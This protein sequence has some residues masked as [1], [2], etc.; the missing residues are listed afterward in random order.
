MKGSPSL[1]SDARGICGMKAFK[2]LLEDKSC[3]AAGSNREAAISSRAVFRLV[4]LFPSPFMA[5]GCVPL[6]AALR[7]PHKWVPVPG[8]FLDT[9][10]AYLYYTKTV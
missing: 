2:T 10:V 8:F 6:F 7:P 1:L 9:Q 3:D 5:V 4:F